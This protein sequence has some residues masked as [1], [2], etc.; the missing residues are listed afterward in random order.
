MA[1]ITYLN[2]STCIAAYL[3]TVPFTG[4]LQYSLLL[5]ACIYSKKSLKCSFL[6]LYH[7]ILVY[8]TIATLP[9]KPMTLN[10]IELNNYF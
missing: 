10:L 4:K 5:E 7:M 9:S 3:T 6:K 2:A 8:Q 1:L